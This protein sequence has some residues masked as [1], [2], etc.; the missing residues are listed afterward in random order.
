MFTVR[1][2]KVFVLGIFLALPVLAASPK[3]SP[4]T[5]QAAT[6]S[7]PLTALEVRQAEKRLADLGY[8]S[9]G[10]GRLDG[11]M[12]E[13]FRGALI[14][15][16][17]IDGRKATG[18]LTRRDLTALARAVPPLPRETG[19]AHIEVDLGRQ[20]LFFVDDQGK[21]A[22]ILPV[23]S[24]S[25]KNFH[26]AGYPETHAV[27]PCGHLEVFEKE[28]GWKKSP[29]GEMFNPLYIVGGIAIHGSLDVP[30]YPASH[31]CIRVPMFAAH[32]LPK[33]VPLKTPVLVYGCRD[34]AAP[35]PVLATAAR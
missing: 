18:Q 7:G 8:W 33:M 25:G 21:V 26:E 28:A 14:A 31:G 11:R 34:E 20:V 16:Q 24:G 2:G 9:A 12:D 17:K 23:S 19:P 30:A 29:L 15:F 5:A 3:A 32:Q 13:V 27:T 10:S 35:V 6:K 4:A 1:F 22:H